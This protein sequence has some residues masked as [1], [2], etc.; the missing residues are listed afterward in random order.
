[1]NGRK[2]NVQRFKGL[3]EMNAEQ[4]WAT[5]MDPDR[6]QLLQVHLEDQFR[7]EEVFATLMGND[8]GARRHFIQQNAKDVRFLDI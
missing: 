6:R 1:M 5:T 3:G 2:L 7:A 8:V 4:L